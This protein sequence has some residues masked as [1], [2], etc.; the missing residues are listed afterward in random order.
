MEENMLRIYVSEHCTQTL[1]HSC[2]LCIQLLPSE[3]GL[4]HHL[5]TIS[6]PNHLASSLIFLGVRLGRRVCVTKGVAAG[7][8]W[9]ERVGIS[10]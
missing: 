8:G 3:L 2:I 6:E 10:S 4:H 7:G 9:Y 1:P 5:N